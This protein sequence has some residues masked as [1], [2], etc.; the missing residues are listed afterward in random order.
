MSRKTSIN[1][2]IEE[3]HF[4]FT[5]TER[6]EELLRK[7]TELLNN[8]IKRTHKE[9]DGAYE[10]SKNLAVSALLVIAELLGKLDIESVDVLEGELEEIK[11]ILEDS[12]L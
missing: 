6:E 2:Y 11:R 8:R 7:A 9:T 1:L 5:A 4:S 12:I 3:H 10:T